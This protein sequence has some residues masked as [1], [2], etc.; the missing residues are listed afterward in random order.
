MLGAAIGDDRAALAHDVADQLAVGLRDEVQLRDEG[1]VGADPMDDEG[2]L[3][4][5][6]REIPEGVEGEHLGGAVVGTPFLANDHGFRLDGMGQP[7]SPYMHQTPPTTGSPTGSALRHARQRLAA[8]LSPENQHRP[9][10]TSPASKPLTN[11]P[12]MR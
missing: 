7:D 6:L 12:P 5:G 9:T 1:G 4:A 10:E 8:E 11:P 2:F 3:G